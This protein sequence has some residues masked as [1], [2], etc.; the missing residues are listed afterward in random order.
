M[1]WFGDEVEV[2]AGSGA[3]AAERAAAR[4]FGAVL[5]GGHASTIPR[6]GEFPIPR[7][8][9]SRSGGP[10]GNPEQGPPLV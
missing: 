9:N 1:P 10:V 3:G 2:V 5:A 4:R 6:A 8:L 7:A